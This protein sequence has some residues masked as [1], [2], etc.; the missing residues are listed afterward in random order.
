[1]GS[2]VLVGHVCL[3]PCKRRIIQ[4]ILVLA[5]DVPA[6]NPSTRIIRMFE[7][8]SSANPSRYQAMTSAQIAQRS[9][10]RAQESISSM[11]TS[12]LIRLTTKVTANGVLVVLRTAG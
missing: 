2:W 1:M 12:A 4:S 5:N 11:N 3:R 8:F 10:L 6:Q 9:L 7:A